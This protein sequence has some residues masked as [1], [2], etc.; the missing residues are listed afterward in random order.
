M[1]AMDRF[2]VEFLLNT[3]VQLCEPPLA[4]SHILDCLLETARNTLTSPIY[5]RE[6][7]NC[8]QV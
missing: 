5:G 2:Q 8:K 1:Q 6:I 4:L 7:Q 3:P